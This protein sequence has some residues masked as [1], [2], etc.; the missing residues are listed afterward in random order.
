MEGESKMITIISIIS[1]VIGLLI[2]YIVVYFA[3]KHGI[4]NS[5][6]GHFI[7]NK[8]GDEATETNETSFLDRDLDND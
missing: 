6:V 8:Y 3:V 1:W 7:E 5:V 4:N 2:L